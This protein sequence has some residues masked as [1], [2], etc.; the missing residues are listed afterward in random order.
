MILTYPFLFV[1]T[2]L[3]QFWHN[4]GTIQILFILVI[5]VLLKITK[6][7]QSEI[8]VNNKVYSAL[9]MSI[10]N[11]VSKVKMYQFSVTFKDKNMILSKHNKIYTVIKISS[12]IINK[13]NISDK[14]IF[15]IAFS[16]RKI[17]IKTIDPSEIK[18]GGIYKTGSMDGNRLRV[19]IPTDIKK[20]CNLSAGIEF[21]ETIKDGS[22]T[23][24]YERPR[25]K[26]L[27]QEEKEVFK[28]KKQIAEIETKQ[29][30]K[31]A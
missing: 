22:L 15:E 30:L 11:S 12:K 29:Q 3:A 19:L 21:K 2:L 20:I 27:S 24:S 6:Y 31:R 14:T 13:C 18:D 28:L 1:S 9:K 4:F 16:D 26:R 10:I 5:A 8:K 7:S 25:K 23:L 17:T